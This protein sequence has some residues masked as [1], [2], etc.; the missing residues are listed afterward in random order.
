MQKWQVNHANTVRN[1]SQL[2]TT[3]HSY[4]QQLTITN[5]LQTKHNPHQLPLLT[6]SAADSLL[7]SDCK[8]YQN[9]QDIKY[10]L[11]NAQIH[12]VPSVCHRLQ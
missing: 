7:P 10:K 3:V 4:Q 2:T 6:L 8:K 5:K 1:S 9:T 11:K 12:P